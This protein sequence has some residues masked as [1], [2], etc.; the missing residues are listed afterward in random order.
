MN[1]DTNPIVNVTSHTDCSA[2]VT[3]ARWLG[4]CRH[5]IN[6]YR[7]SRR[8]SNQ[9]SKRYTAPCRDCGR[10]VVW[11]ETWKDGHWVLA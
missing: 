9:H 10:R 6:P 11:D 4:L 3:N 8:G 5:V 1:T 2:T 7:V